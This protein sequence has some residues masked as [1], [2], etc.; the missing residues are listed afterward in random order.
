MPAFAD[1]SYWHRRHVRKHLLVVQMVWNHPGFPWQALVSEL[2]DHVATHQRIPPN[3]QFSTIHDDFS[4]QYI[5]VME[6][7]APHF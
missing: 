1:P 6:F 4:Q 5:Q 3:S 2:C 7:L